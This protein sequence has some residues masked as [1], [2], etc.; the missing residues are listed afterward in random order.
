MFEKIIDYFSLVSTEPLAG[1]TGTNRQVKL[2]IGVL[3]G[4]LSKVIYDLLASGEGVSFSSFLIAAIASVVVFP[5]I[6]KEAGLN[7][8]PLTFSKW[9]LAFQNGFFWGVTMGALSG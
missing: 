4:A 7:K 8:G 3:L 1:G 9:C 6:Y 5:H 2:Y